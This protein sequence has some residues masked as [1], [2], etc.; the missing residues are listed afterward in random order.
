M[1]RERRTWSGRVEWSPARVARPGSEAEV[2]EV[3]RAAARDGL[4]VRPIGSG[5]SS[6]PL[7]ATEG[8]TLDLRGWAGIERLDPERGLATVRAGTV[9]ADLGAPLREHGFA[10]HNQGDVDVQTVA[11]AIGTGTHG[12]G[13]ALG[14]LSS[15][16]A[17]A[18]LVTAAGEVVHCDAARDPDLF[19]VARLS[20]GSAGVI[21]AV[22]LRVVPAY[23]L[24]ERVWFE[25]ATSCLARL[26]E[27]VAATR[28]YELWWYPGRDLCEQKSLHPTDAEPDPLPDRKRE[29]IDHSYRVFP[30]VRDLRFQELEYAVPAGAGPA[31]LAAI[32]AVVLERFPDLQW[33]VE[34]RTVAADDVWL[35]PAHRRASVT[36]SV[37][38]DHELPY[39]RLFREC[40]AVFGAFGGRPHWGKVHWLGPETLA[41]LYPRWADFWA[42]RD[43][44]DPEG[45]F[46]NDHLRRLAGVDPVLGDGVDRW[47]HPAW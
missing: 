20:L 47:R 32:R 30:T 38:Q 37:H 28:H 41:P 4:A 16:V 27:R 34:Y 43:R 29:R 17:G 46:L 11:G 44:I 6:M 26:D 23:N 25:D 14:S 33:P 40:E 8:V 45:R 21:T 7:V 36:I 31:C 39:E 15:A 19:E 12:T 18:R 22:T 10:L 9:L 13:P 24:H 3:V 2:A 5:H 42:T 1:D 35:S